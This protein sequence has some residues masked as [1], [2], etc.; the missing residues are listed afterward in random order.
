CNGGFYYGHRWFHCWW[1]PGHGSQAFVGALIRSCDTYFYQV[2]LRVGIDPL[3]SWAERVGLIGRTGIDLPQ[4]RKSFVP[5]VGWYNSRFGS[6]GWGRG[7]ILSLAIGQAEM[8]ETPLSLAA[9]Y[10][11]LVK[12]G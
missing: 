12:R 4:E 11:L 7:V 10:S 5:S 1:H 2:G 8:L 6:R 9:F 3:H